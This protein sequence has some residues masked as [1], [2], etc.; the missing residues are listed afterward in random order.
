MSY[1]NGKHIIDSW[2]VNSGG[3]FDEIIIKNE[4]PMSE[5]HA[6]QLSAL[7]SE[8]DDVLG[9][10]QKKNSQM[11]FLM[12]LSIKL[13]MHMIDVMFLRFKSFQLQL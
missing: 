1:P 2:I 6:V 8:R 9:N 12:Q 10:F 7:L 4:M 13:G 3:L 5:I 11:V